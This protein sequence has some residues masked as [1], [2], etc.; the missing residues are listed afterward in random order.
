[1][2][3]RE[4]AERDGDGI[5]VRL[6][7]DDSA[8]PG[9]DVRVDYRDERLGVFFSIRPPRDEALEA[10]HHPNAYARVARHSRVVVST[11]AT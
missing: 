8:P 7:W 10:F 5:V 3:L 1:M 9:H 4:L 11:R 2:T 6:L